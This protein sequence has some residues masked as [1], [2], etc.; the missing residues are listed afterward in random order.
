MK[1]IAVTLSLLYGDLQFSSVFRPTKDTLRQFRM[2]QLL[3]NSNAPDYRDVCSNFLSYL[4]RNRNDVEYEDFGLDEEDTKYFA[5]R[6][7]NT[8]WQEVTDI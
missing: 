6:E 5:R 7:I 2:K 3:S 4:V 1:A 8:L